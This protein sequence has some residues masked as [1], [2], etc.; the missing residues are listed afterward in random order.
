MTETGKKGHDFAALDYIAA[1][2]LVADSTGNI[3]FM[4][5]AVKRILGYTSPEVLGNGWWELVG[6]NGED[7]LYRRQ[8][9]AG[10]AAGTIDLGTRKIY[11]T[12]VLSKTGDTVW[13]QWTNSRTTDNLLVGVGQIITERKE[14]EEKLHRYSQQV[15]LLHT[16]DKIILSMAPLQNRIE[17]VLEELEKNISFVSRTTLAVMDDET[18]TARLYRKGRINELSE[19]NIVVPVTAL[20]SID[21]L[22]PGKHYLVSDLTRQAHLSETDQENLRDGIISYLAM[23]LYFQEKLIGALFLCSSVPDPFTTQDLVLAHDVSNSLA[24]GIQQ[25]RLEQTL[26]QKNAEKELLLKEIH[27]R[28]KNNL[29]VISSLLNMQS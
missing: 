13:I 5:T 10:M 28:V 11:E 14:I 12:P 17:A 21:N 23:P 8:Q 26:I 1:I 9:V 20:R 16:I 3:V 15:H 7:S 2:V 6:N 4:N 22:A 24:L 19:N 25:N 29:Q 27:H 18:Q